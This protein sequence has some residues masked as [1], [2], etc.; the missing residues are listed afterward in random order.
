MSEIN[1]T[2]VVEPITL[3]VTQTPITQTVTVAPID[4]SVFT[5]APASNPP[6]TPNASLQYYTT[7]WGKVSC[8][9]QLKTKNLLKTNALYRLH[10]YNF[11]KHEQEQ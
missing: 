5:S 3:D 1:A 8:L 10:Q 4:L 7:T 6:G 9:Y 2:I 11:L